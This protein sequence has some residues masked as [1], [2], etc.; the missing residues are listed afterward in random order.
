[1]D[2]ITDVIKADT[3]NCSRVDTRYIELMSASAKDLSL[4][5]REASLRLNLIY[6]GEYVNG[7]S[8]WES[9]KLSRRLEKALTKCEEA[10][11]LLK[12]ILPKKGKK[13]NKA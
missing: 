4:A 2:H 6:S 11:E 13:K 10:E 7:L 3:L 12:T 1:V 9:V 8:F 5:K